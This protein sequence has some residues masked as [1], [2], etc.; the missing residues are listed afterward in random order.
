[1]VMAA[2]MTCGHKSSQA[3]RESRDRLNVRSKSH[4][5][6]CV[7]G[8]LLL[9]CR[10]YQINKRARLSPA[11][12]L[13]GDVAFQKSCSD[14]VALMSANFDESQTSYVILQPL[15]VESFIPSNLSTK[16]AP[17]KFIVNLQPV[18]VVMHG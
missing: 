10:R 7:V 13:Y 17:W 18:P 12:E 6:P 14:H 5:I 16:L 9:P 15:H 8:V 2:M 1:M 4:H 11:H 3:P